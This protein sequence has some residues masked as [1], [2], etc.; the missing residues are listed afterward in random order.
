MSKNPFVDFVMYYEIKLINPETKEVYFKVTSARPKFP[1][2]E[3][4]DRFKGAML[5]IRTTCNP[6]SDQ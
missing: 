5:V 6:D 4:L 3:I 2:Q 1:S